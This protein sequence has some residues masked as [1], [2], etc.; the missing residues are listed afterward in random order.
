VVL[1]V[2]CRLLAVCYCF[3]GSAAREKAKRKLWSMAHAM[4]MEDPCVFKGVLAADNAS[5]LAWVAARSDQ[6]A[7]LHSP[8]YSSCSLLHFCV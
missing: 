6:E 2:L 1:H 4:S 7:C 8:C 3:A 5:A